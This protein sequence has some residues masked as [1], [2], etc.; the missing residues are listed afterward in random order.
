MTGL[1]DGSLGHASFRF[2]LVQDDH[3]LR[4]WLSRALAL[5]VA[6]APTEAVTGLLADHT[7]A[8]IAVERSL[9]AGLLTEM[10]SAHGEHR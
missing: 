5:L 7:A 8:V 9:H 1:G 4:A 2:Y 3:Y 6:R 10:A